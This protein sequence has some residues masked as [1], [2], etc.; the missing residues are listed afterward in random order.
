M[1][2]LT[3]LY[4]PPDDPAAFEDH[5]AGTHVPLV[6][7]VPNLARFEASLVLGTPDGNPAPYHRIA[8]LWFEDAGVLQASM[9]SE[10]GQA[11]VADIANFATGGATVV[12]SEI[13]G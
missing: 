13:D 11:A 1:V 5:Y 9:G 6:D 2:K 4:G 3:V 7:K 8:E 12:I 10:G